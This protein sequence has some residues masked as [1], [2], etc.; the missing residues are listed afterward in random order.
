LPPLSTAGPIYSSSP[1]P[2]ASCDRDVDRRI[3][4]VDDRLHRQPGAAGIS[5]TIA[6]FGV[7]EVPGG[8]KFTVAKRR[9]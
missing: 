9:R 2:T 8:E 4:R 3:I 7:R 1:G 6:L 5:R